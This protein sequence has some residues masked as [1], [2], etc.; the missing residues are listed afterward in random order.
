MMMMPASKNCS[1][2]FLANYLVCSK[3]CNQKIRT[4]T[5]AKEAKRE[6]GIFPSFLEQH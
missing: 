5:R 1:C 2:L 3:L 4:F 6:V